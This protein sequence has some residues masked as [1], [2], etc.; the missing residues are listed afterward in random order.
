LGNSVNL[1]S[2]VN[3]NNPSTTIAFNSFETGN[4][5]GY[6]TNGQGSFESGSSG[7][8]DRPANASFVSSG[9]NSFMARNESAIIQ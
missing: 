6:T 3:F 1:S 9:S 8:G 2:T 7:N 5:W 4:S